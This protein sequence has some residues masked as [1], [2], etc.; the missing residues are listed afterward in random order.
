[1]LASNPGVLIDTAIWIFVVALL[2]VRFV[3]FIGDPLFGTQLDPTE[4]G[5]KFGRR[6]V[7]GVAFACA[8]VVIGVF[9][10]HP[11]SIVLVRAGQAVFAYYLL[12]LI[13]D[14]LLQR[15]RRRRATC[16]RSKRLLKIEALVGLAL[17]VIAIA[18]GI[19]VG[20]ALRGP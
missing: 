18:V 15:I 16:G 19:S 9:L 1:M 12:A 7:R 6:A 8:A 10:D 5:S 3:V 17:L 2:T 4:D 14:P 11:S 20:N 13:A